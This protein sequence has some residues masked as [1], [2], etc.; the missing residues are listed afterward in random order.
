MRGQTQTVGKM[1]KTYTLLFLVVTVSVTFFCIV[2]YGL[3]S[4]VES[5]KLL[6]NSLIAG[7]LA[8]IG[9]T[10]NIFLVQHL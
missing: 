3:I 9:V 2:S 10:I 7:P 8:G 6:R 1:L 5:V 4:D